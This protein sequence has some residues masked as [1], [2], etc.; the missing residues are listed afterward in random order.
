VTT[1]ALAQDLAAHALYGPPTGKTWEPTRQDR[2]THPDI[3][4]HKPHPWTVL[5][6]TP[7]PK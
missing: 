2:L 6:I 3:Q 7:A 5:T 1:T 4:P